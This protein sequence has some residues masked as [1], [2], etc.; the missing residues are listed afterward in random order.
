MADRIARM[1]EE[2]KENDSILAATTESK[3]AAQQ[4]ARDAEQLRSSAEPRPTHLAQIEVMVGSTRVRDSGK[5]DREL[6]KHL[7]E[8]EANAR[9]AGDAVQEAEWDV[10]K[11]MEAATELRTACDAATQNGRSDAD[12]YMRCGAAM[13]ELEVAK[14]DMEKRRQELE[15]AVA[16]E[17]RA[18]DARIDASREVEAALDDA[19]RQEPTALMGGGIC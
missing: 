4:R 15:Y 2:S 7:A 12:L 1:M 19:I 18:R 16:E 11:K 17:Q 10:A 6:W 14:G 13:L 9:K 8:A 3:N 5:K